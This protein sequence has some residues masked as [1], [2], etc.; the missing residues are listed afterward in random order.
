VSSFVGF[1]LFVRPAL[2]LMMGKKEPYLVQLRAS[3]TQPFRYTTDRPTYYPVVLENREG[4][5]QITPVPWFGSP[6]L[7]GLTRANALACLPA[8]ESD[9][10]AGE[11]VHVIAVEPPG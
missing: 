4:V 9:F 1:E 10:R 2:R 6:D 5:W 7:R 11:Y 8:G 3:W